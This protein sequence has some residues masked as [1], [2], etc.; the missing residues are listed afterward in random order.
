MKFGKIVFCEYALTDFGASSAG[1]S[2]LFEAIGLY[3]QCALHICICI[4]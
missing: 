1:A 2:S 4:S 3:A